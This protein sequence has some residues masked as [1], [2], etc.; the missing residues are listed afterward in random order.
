MYASHGIIPS[1]A[2]VQR[3]SL[4]L[5]HCCRTLYWSQLIHQS[6]T[7]EASEWKPTSQAQFMLV[8]GTLVS[9]VTQG[10]CEVSEWTPTSQAQFMLVS[11]TLV[12]VVTQVT[13]EASEWT[14]TSQ[15]Q[16]MLVSGT[17]VSVVTQVTREASEWTPTSQ[18][19]F[20]LVSGTLVSVVTQVNHS[21]QHQSALSPSIRGH[22][23]CPFTRLTC[24]L[25]VGLN[26]DDTEC[27][28]FPVLLQTL[29][30]QTTRQTM[31]MM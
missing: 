24:Y 31:L 4:L 28:D 27:C 12:S 30:A 26:A 14:P 19:Q 9:V 8:S 10:T 18:A 20:M 6:V 16:F 13:C 22:V 5:D 17:L 15:A 29:K 25:L 1:P 11:G 3:D 7:C 21:T 2:A 23:R